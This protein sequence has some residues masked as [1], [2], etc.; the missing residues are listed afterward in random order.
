MARNSAP[1]IYLEDTIL[2]GQ[3]TADNATF[4]GS[5]QIQVASGED[6]N[7]YTAGSQPGTLANPVLVY[8]PGL[9]TL[10][11]DDSHGAIVLVTLGTTTN[12]TSLDPSEI[13]VKHA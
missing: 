10:S 4:A 3:A 13:I 12:P 1:L 2:T 11:Y 7:L 5:G 6:P 8:N 9:H